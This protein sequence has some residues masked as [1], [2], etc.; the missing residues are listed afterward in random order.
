MKILCIGEEWRGSN[1]SGFFYALTRQGHIIHIV[2]ELSHVSVKA[3]DLFAKICN[4][5][6]R[7]F[8]INDL[9]EQLDRITSA[10]RP[11]LILV[12]KGAFVKPETVHGWK[13]RGIPV[14]IFFPDVSFL[15]HGNLIPACIPLYDH[16]FSTKSFAADDIRRLFRR[17]KSSIS[18]IPHGFDPLIHRPVRS[19]DDTF[20][21]AASFIGSYSAHKQHYL[22]SLKMKLP[23][24]DLKIWGGTW[25]GKSSLKSSVQLISIEGD[26][27]A[28][29]LNQSH[30]NIALL[31]ELVEGASRGDQITSRTFHIPA[32]GGFMLHQ[33]TEEVLHYFD[34]GKE[35]ACFESVDELVEK[36]QFYLNNPIERIRIRDQGY[37]R[38]LAEH[39]LDRRVQLVM[40]ILKDRGLV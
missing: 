31:S 19:V 14:I 18:F 36:V 10:F 22:V 16:I 4:R 29:A 34:E 12:Y 26:Q 28:L 1:S 40:T 11:N 35:M 38:A 24:L 3:R 25:S 9:N 27:Y 23:D 32:S 30:V 8:Q 37:K 33:R 21:C 15:A 5:L 2:N 6:I 39:S 13:A 17:D 7:Q 20:S